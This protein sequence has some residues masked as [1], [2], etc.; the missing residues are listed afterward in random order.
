MCLRKA[1]LVAAAD[2]LNEF[3]QWE[4]HGNDGDADDGGDEEHGERREDAG[5]DAEALFG[6]LFVHAGEGGEGGGEV[7]G[8][9]AEFK[10]CR[11]GGREEL[12]VEFGGRFSGVEEMDELLSFGGEAFGAGGVGSEGNGAGE[13]E[14]GFDTEAEGVAPAGD[15]VG[16]DDAAD[17]GDVDAEGI[18][19]GGGAAGGAEDEK[20][21]EQNGDGDGDDREEIGVVA[22]GIHDELGEGGERSAEVFKDVGK[23]R[24]D[25]D[26]NEEHDEGECYQN[27]DGVGEGAP[28]GAAEAG[29]EFE[30]AAEVEEHGGEVGGLDAGFDEAAVE[31]GKTRGVVGEGG[32]HGGAVFE[33]RGDGVGGG[34]ET[35][36]VHVGGDEAEAALDGETG[37]GEVGEL[38]VE[39]EEIVGAEGSAAGGRGGRGGDVEDAEVDGGEALGG[40][41][42]GGGIEGS[43]E[44]FAGGGLGFVADLGGLDRRDN[45][46]L[47][48]VFS[49]GG[50]LLRLG[51]VK[52]KRI[53]A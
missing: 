11:D 19:E 32:L 29:H 35:T 13:I 44:D 34:G 24:D 41:G 40:V 50:E 36:G 20:H 25:D 10:G 21:E 27:G 12:A 16:T 45:G 46:G 4:E 42:R 52:V 49:P 22:G 14:A 37:G 8:A 2:A 5:E 6:L 47:G 31:G 17:D 30:M 28:E 3:D 38:L 7:A 1:D 51:R 23:S 26:G 9:R 48:H 39:D 15:E 53:K 43:A 33:F 18:R